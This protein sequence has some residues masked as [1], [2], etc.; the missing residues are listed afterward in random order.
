M[1]KEEV[2]PHKANPKIPTIC[3]SCTYNGSTN[4]IKMMMMMPKE[5]P[6]THTE[7]AQRRSKIDLPNDHESTSSLHEQQRFASILYKALPDCFPNFYTSSS[8][9]ILKAL[10]FG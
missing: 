4:Q 9:R 8:V 5:A 1:G 7:A 10:R 2:H 3:Q 6:Y